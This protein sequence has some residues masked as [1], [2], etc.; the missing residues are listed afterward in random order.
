MK[1][2]DKN[3]TSTPSTSSITPQPEPSPLEIAVLK[4]KFEMEAKMAK[5]WGRLST[6]I[7]V[8]VDVLSA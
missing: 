6:A 7:I 2:N 5:K 4:E 3:K 1:R 8:Q